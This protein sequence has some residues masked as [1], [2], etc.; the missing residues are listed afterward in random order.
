MFYICFVLLEIVCVRMC[1]RDLWGLER[2]ISQYEA[3]CATIR[4]RILMP[5]T[6]IN[7]Q[8]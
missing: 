7:F 1:V 2:L 4:T 3:Y 6:H 5:R 8:N